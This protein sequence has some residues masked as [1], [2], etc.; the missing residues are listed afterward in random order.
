M[1]DWQH[2]L[3]L[4]MQSDV[5]DIKSLL[6]SIKHKLEE[7]TT[8]LQRGALLLL[9]WVG[10]ILLNLDPEKAAQFVAHLLAK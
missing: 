8:W 6:R 4:Q 7:L 2:Y 3:L 1:N 9:L 10:G 5:K